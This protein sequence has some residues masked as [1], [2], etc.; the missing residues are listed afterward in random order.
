MAKYLTKAQVVADYV[1][2]YLDKV[3]KD[4]REVTWRLM[5]DF[6]LKDKRIST[7]QHSSWKFPTKEVNEFDNQK[8][9]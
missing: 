1:Q 6:M 8:N 5:L 2:H 4:D 9:R 3:S 7:T